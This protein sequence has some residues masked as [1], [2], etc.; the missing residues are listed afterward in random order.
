MIDK[1]N[2]APHNEACWNYVSGL[3]KHYQG[4]CFDDVAYE[5]RR[6]IVCGECGIIM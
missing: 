4:A 6:F 5:A 1:L 2:T 3:M